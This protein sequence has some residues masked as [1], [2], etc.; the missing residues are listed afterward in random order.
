MPL[1]QI[2]N[3][4]ADI[5]RLLR[6]SAG[7]LGEPNKVLWMCII[8]KMPGRMLPQGSVQNRDIMI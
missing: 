3:E 7:T 2:Y 5:I 1:L 6:R 4:G 8:H